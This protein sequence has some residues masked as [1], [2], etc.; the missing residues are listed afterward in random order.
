[1]NVKISILI[2]NDDSNNR[3]IIYI[4]PQIIQSLYTFHWQKTIETLEKSWRNPGEIDLQGT[5]TPL[6]SRSLGSARAWSNSRAM[7]PSCACTAL[8]SGLLALG[9]ESVWFPHLGM[10]M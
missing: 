8:R 3:K 4:I 5:Q 9:D 1:M 7:S 10:A 2:D 6:A